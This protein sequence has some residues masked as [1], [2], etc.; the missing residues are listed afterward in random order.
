[1]IENPTNRTK[2]NIHPPTLKLKFTNIGYG[3]P[4]YNSMLICEDN[5]P[6]VTCGPTLRK[7]DLRNNEI[8]LNKQIGTSQIFNIIQNQD[9]IVVIN[10]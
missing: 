8:L 3:N 5:H 1:M 6:L 4:R 7:V 2:I 10:F 9:V